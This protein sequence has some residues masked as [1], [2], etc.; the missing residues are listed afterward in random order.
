MQRI[1]VALQREARELSLV[2]SLHGKL[3]ELNL[4]EVLAL[5]RGERLWRHSCFEAFVAGAGAAGY[6]EYNFA[7]SGLWAAYRLDGY[8]AGMQQ[9]P[10]SA[11]EFS[12][13]RAPGALRLDARVT[14]PEG[15]PA[16]LKIGLSAVI[17]D[18]SGQL[19]YWAL[20]HAPDKPDFHHADAFALQLD[21]AAQS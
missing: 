2:Y 7:P 5:Q 18:A 6:F 21:G 11:P 1:E 10:D 4:P 3:A 20:R 12:V 16:R 9:L 17:E 13:R 14:L 19:S 15:L 8:R